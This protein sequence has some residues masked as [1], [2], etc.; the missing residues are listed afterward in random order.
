M[1]H[2]VIADA[3]ISTSPASDT[4]VTVSQFNAQMKWLYD[5]GYYAITAAQLVTYMTTG[6]LALCPTRGCKQTRPIVLTFDDGWFNQANALPALNKY[7]WKASFNVIAGFPGN[8][9]EYMNWT[10]IKSLVTKGHEIGGHSMTHP[11]QMLL[12]DATVELVTSKSRIESKTGKP[13]VT[14]AWPNGYYTPELLNFAEFVAKYKGSET[15]DDNWCVVMGVEQIFWHCTADGFCDW[16][17]LPGCQYSTGNQRD[18]DEFMIKRIFVDGRCTLEEFTRYVTQ[19]HTSFCVG[20]TPPLAIP[21]AF[22]LTLSAEVP[23]LI[24]KVKRPQSIEDNENE[25]TNHNKRDTID[26]ENDGDDHGHHGKNTD[27]KGKK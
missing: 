15:I 19:Q 5:N 21:E 24:R 1:Y 27:K 4:V 22:S 3:A 18:Q 8:D 25:M 2:E 23:G 26:E 12:S 6:K 13:V 14:L 16:W 17:A 20:M 10:K 11:E 9:P 7:G